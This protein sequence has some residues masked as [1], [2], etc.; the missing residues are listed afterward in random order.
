[1][2]KFVY[3]GPSW[4][5]SS[6]DLPGSDAFNNPTN[7]AKEWQIPY[8]NLSAGGSTALNRVEAIKNHYDSTSPIIF[9]YNE[10]I[11]DLTAVTGLQFSELIQ[12]SDWLDIWKECNQ[13]CL[14]EINSIGR[15]VLLIGGHSDVI[16]CNYSNI[17]VGHN[18]WQRWLA[19][20]SGMITRKGK[21]NVKM[22]DGSSFSFRNCW[23]AEVIHRF[24]HEHP[25]ISPSSEIV[26]SV[27]D[28]FFFWKQLEKADL[29][30]EVHPNKRATELY[31]NF[32]LPVV[33]E[34]LENNIK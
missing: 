4:A 17:T 6:F 22:D 24:M 32:L 31:A 7:L 1:M 2:M 26:D 9:V 27:W 16:D 23:G 13:Y 5:E 21:V 3:A 34:F 8:S 29:F 18:S 28:I 14:N 12:R 15:P 33:T 10:P 25:D 19:E 30:F 11:G 20:Q